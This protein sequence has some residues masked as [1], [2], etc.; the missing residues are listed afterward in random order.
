MKILYITDTFFPDLSGGATRAYYFCK[1]LHD[2]GHELH[3]I[4][5][6]KQKTIG[7]E[8]D[9]T[10]CPGRSLV[11]LFPGAGYLPS[12]V[13]SAVRA[14]KK[15]DIDVI[16]AS[17]PS[18]SAMLSGYIC[19]KIV[20]KPL[21]A[22]IRDPYIRSFPI[23]SRTKSYVYQ[24]S[25]KGALLACLERRVLKSASRIIV[26]NPAIGDE[27]RR[28][29][30][31]GRTD[32]I[33]TG[34]DAAGQRKSTRRNR[35][36][37]VYAGR[38]LATKQLD[39]VIRALP[40]LDA[41]F[42]ICGDGD[43]IRHLKQAA[44]ANGMGGRVVFAG[45]LPHRKALSVINSA[46]ILFLGL[47]TS[48]VLKYALPSKVF[49]YMASGKPV[50]SIAHPDG[51]LGLMLKRHSCGIN[52][53]PDAKEVAAAVKELMNNRERYGRNG[54]EAIEKYYRRS[55]QPKRLLQILMRAAGEL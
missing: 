43:Y 1:Y 39:V 44:R 16:F 27:V 31:L 2:R 45:R 28:V 52:C 11:W 49:E 25:L 3:V 22:E 36:R 23:G 21:V 6:K 7:H 42:I 34:A 30:N 5:S 33:Y 14:C 26:T 9:M 32:V 41:E 10:Y 46:D 35:I 50:L 19:H 18:F 17:C 51:D 12:F 4:T 8:W 37:I 55:E 20:K 38:V 47:E 53:R 29:H 15:F 13:S 48:R 40:R 24:K 54:R